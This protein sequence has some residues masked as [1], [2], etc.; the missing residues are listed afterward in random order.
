MQ[1]VLKETV[2]LLCQNSLQF[3]S[4]FSVEA[5]VAITLDQSEVVLVNIKETIHAT[6]TDGQISYL[7]G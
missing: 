2:V 6:S 3:Q 1:S 5:L 7:L 4:E